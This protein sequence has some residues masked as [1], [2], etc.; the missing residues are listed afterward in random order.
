MTMVVWFLDE[1]GVLTAFQALV[2]GG[3]VLAVVSYWLKRS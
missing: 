3:I 1:F 2:I